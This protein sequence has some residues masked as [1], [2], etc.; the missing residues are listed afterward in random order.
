[1]TG[2]I[3]RGK[4]L[5]S[6]E[7]NIF[8]HSIALMYSAGIQ[9]EEAV[10]L[11]CQSS[12]GPLHNAACAAHKLL[13]NGTP[14]SKA[15]SQTHQFP[16]HAIQVIETGEH[17]GHLEETLNALASY[18]GEEARLLAKMRTAICYPFILLCILSVVLGFIALSVL[19]A[20]MNV[21]KSMMNGIPNSS[22]ITMQVGTIIVWVALSFTLILTVLMLIALIM[23]RTIE[24]EK[25]LIRIIMPLPFTHSIMR[26]IALSR[27][28]S[29]LGIYTAAG[30]D[31]DSAVYNSL[32][33]IENTTLHIRAKKAYA[34]MTDSSNPVGFVEAFSE[35]KIFSTHHLRALTF[36]A[37]IGQIDSAL[38]KTSEELFAQAISQ[39][40]S[41]IDKIQPSIVGF[42]AVAIGLTLI[43]IMLPLIGIPTPI[44]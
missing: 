10:L 18:Y 42:I 36:G 25:R 28:T 19:P 11:L 27:F 43:A 6:A 24:G 12:K 20:L 13:I 9:T 8:F 23:C 35:S 4:Q 17:T 38:Q 37:K 33:T 1:M 5:S 44:K 40:D 29:A 15:I 32:K 39:L 34:A 7:L 30:E 26:T 41:A 16:T 14:L 21:Y 22:F 2:N 3:N 31:L